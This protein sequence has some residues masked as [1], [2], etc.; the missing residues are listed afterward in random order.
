MAD[1]A[2]VFPAR[3]EKERRLLAFG[4]RTLAGYEWPYF[5]ISGATD[6]PTLGLIA[7]V[8]GAEYPPIDAVMQ[9]CGTLLRAESLADVRKELSGLA[10]P[11]LRA[12]MLA[13]RGPMAAYGA[14]AAQ[15]TG[16]DVLDGLTTAGDLP[17]AAH[18]CV[19]NNASECY[20]MIVCIRSR[21]RLQGHKKNR[22]VRCQATR[23]RKFAMGPQDVTEE[24]CA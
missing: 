18:A 14:R 23:E 5:A 15:L 9:F 21:P 6:G 22:V 3:G 13:L 12:A 8:H 2:V 4:S 16:G 24:P 20:V 10:D 7:D 17:S 19:G 1:N 11:D